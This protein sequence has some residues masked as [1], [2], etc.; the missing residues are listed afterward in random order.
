M[1]STG[2]AT[3]PVTLDYGKL[4]EPDELASDQFYQTTR[5]TYYS[6]PELRLMAAVLEDAVATLTTDQRR[7]SRRQQR[8]FNETLKWLNAAEGCD[9]VFSFVSVCEALTLDPDYLR[10]G[11]ERKIAEIGNS[12]RERSTERNRYSSPRRKVVRMR[13][14]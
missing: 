9:W 7:C 14:G 10:R 1:F 3:L 5:R 11:L 13:A 6:S 4:F 8:E 12:R 2:A